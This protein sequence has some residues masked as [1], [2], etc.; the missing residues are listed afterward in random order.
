MIN[1]RDASM[2]S[3]LSRTSVSNRKQWSEWKRAWYLRAQDLSKSTVCGLGLYC[4]LSSICLNFYPRV[5][6]RFKVYAELRVHPASSK[7][8]TRD[9]SSPWIWVFWDSKEE[10]FSRYRTA[11]AKAV[12][13]T[14]LGSWKK[15]ME[16]MVLKPNKRGWG[17]I[18]FIISTRELILAHLPELREWANNIWM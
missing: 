3:S 13:K 15:R 1:S 8:S 16:T 5:V 7:C 6:W 17:F 14:K 9:F 18:W 2:V 12:A 10:C 4:D 11:G